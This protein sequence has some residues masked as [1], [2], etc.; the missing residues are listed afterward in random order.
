MEKR[1]IIKWAVIFVIAS[2]GSLLAIP[3]EITWWK[4]ECVSILS[5]FTITF[6]PIVVDYINYKLQL[7]KAV[8]NG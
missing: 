7:I 1:N 5:A 3:L 6:V 8:K 2:L 4:A